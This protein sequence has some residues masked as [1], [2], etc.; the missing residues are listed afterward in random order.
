M[1]MSAAFREL[2][3]HEGVERPRQR[4]SLSIEPSEFGFAVV[5]RLDGGEPS[6]LLHRQQ[7]QKALQEHKRTIKF[8]V[9]VHDWEVKGVDGSTTHLSRLRPLDADEP[10]C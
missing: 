8:L 5:Y 7:E 1:P 2:S 6:V 10:G 3:D 4:A 9:D